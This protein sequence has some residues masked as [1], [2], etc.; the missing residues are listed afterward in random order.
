MA[1][2]ILNRPRTHL[3][4]PDPHAHPDHSNERFN[5]LAGLI[6]DIRPDVVVNLGDHFDM[7]SLSGFDRGTKSFIGRNYMKD[8]DSGIDA[9][10]RMWDPVKRSKK[11]LPYRVVLEGNHEHRIKRAINER[12]EL[13]GA[14]SFDQL[15]FG[16]FYD[17]CVEY[18]GNTPGVVN[19]D[20][21]YYSH[22]SIS[23]VMG[24]PIGGEHAAY[25]LLAKNF[26]SCTVG[27]SHTV[28][29]A[30]RTTVSGQKILGCVAGVYQDYDSDWAGECN[31]LWWRG[32]VVKRNV[33][34]GVYDPQF[35]SIDQLRKEYS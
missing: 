28:D 26:V 34:E 17:S 15:A 24:R 5:W 2:L 7:P 10:H 14:V 3:V 19:I 18:S 22:F 1:G 9:H 23:G 21:V 11:K 30:V 27:H 8:I 31:K 32:V 16:E 13:D 35:I 20:G 6:K 25:S 4:I 29:F 12:P 33:F